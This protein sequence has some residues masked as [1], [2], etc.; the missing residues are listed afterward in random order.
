MMQGDN[1]Y[2]ALHCDKRRRHPPY[3]LAMSR[4]PAMEDV[5]QV[6]LKEASARHSEAIVVILSEAKDLSV[7]TG[8]KILRLRL[9]DDG[10]RLWL[11]LPGAVSL[12]A[13]PGS[14]DDGQHSTS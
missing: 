12:G 3:R 8:E 14:S 10:V 7:T 6:I 4:Y 9:Q 5:M 1:R 2:E 11:R 13:A